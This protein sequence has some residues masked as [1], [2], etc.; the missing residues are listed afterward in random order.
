MVLIERLFS[1]G[2]IILLSFIMVFIFAA[3]Y[4]AA[5]WNEETDKFVVEM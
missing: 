2:L 1:I 5:A 4:L 3:Y